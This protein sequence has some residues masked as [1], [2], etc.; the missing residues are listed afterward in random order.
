MV[1][2]ACGLA[3]Y[4]P[5]RH[6]THAS[7]VA[8]DPQ[9]RDSAE[10]IDNKGRQLQ[11]AWDYRRGGVLQAAARV[12]DYPHVLPDVGVPDRSHFE[13]KRGKSLYIPKEVPAP[14]EA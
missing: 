12:H 8:L 2:L 14:A 13:W 11:K 9:M 7:D 3:V 6:I 1:G 5:I 10:S 4:T